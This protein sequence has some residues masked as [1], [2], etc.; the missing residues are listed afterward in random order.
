MPTVNFTYP[1]VYIE[2]ISSGSHA[3]TGVPTSVT[4][5]VGRTLMGPLNEPTDCF[6]YADYE[7]YFGGLSA[8]YPLAY[9][10]QDF[11]DNGGDHAI[12]VRVFHDMA[13]GLVVQ[14]ATATFAALSGGG[15]EIQAIGPGKFG[16]SIAL[17][18]DYLGLRTIAA[19]P[20]TATFE[21]TQ[22][23]D[24]TPSGTVVLTMTASPGGAVKATY[25]INAGDTVD[26]IAQG[27]ATSFNAA[28]STA[29]GQAQVLMATPTRAQVRFQTQT[30]GTGAPAVAWT[31]TPGTGFQIAATPPGTSATAGTF[32]AGASQSGAAASGTMTV[33]GPASAA[34]T[35]TF[36]ATSPTGSTALATVPVTAGQTVKSL[37]AGIQSAFNLAFGGPSG[38]IAPV[39]VD[40]TTF[41]LTIAA[42]QPG[43]PGNSVQIKQIGTLPAGVKVTPPALPLTGGVN[44]GY[45]DAPAIAAAQQFE[46]Y[47][48]APDDLF[49]VTVTYAPPGGGAPVTERYNSVSLT[50]E[51]SPTR[52]DRAI[53]QASVLVHV[54][55]SPAYPWSPYPSTV[56][57][58]FP[59]QSPTLLSAKGGS[60]S[61]ALQP[62]DFAGDQLAQTGMYA[63][64]TVDIFNLL[65][66]PPDAAPSDTLPMTGVGQDPGLYAAAADFCV[67]QRAMLLC[68]PPQAW[69]SYAQAGRYNLMQPTDVGITDQAGQQ[70]SAVY[71]P[72]IQKEDLLSGTTKSFS[73]VGSIAGQYATTDK[74][75]G[76]WKAPAGISTGLS[77]VTA[78]DFKMT[79]AQDGEINP[80]GINAL[81][82]FNVIGP[83]IWGARTLRGADVLA[84]DFKYV[85][86][87]RLTLY[88]ESSLYQG[89]Q[90]AVFEPNAEPLWSSLRLAVNG[91]MAPLQQQGA[92]YGYSVQCDSKTTTAADIELGVCNIIVAF[93]PVLPAEF[94]VLKIQQQT[95]ASYSS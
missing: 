52:I 79:D 61:P 19:T 5:F 73:P 51:H 2:E 86:A 90:W 40:P 43:V 33:G 71:F 63:L 87:R 81:R 36:L 76:V 22:A 50:G 24:A 44:P 59:G 15:A 21:L 14:N 72:R 65:C 17:S 68:D 70:N 56:V 31:L 78:L 20:A 30:A 37:A 10:V 39:T 8:S 11:F 75:R 26:V 27:L 1:G 80:L 53:N 92:F 91:F 64:Q 66:L 29:F 9:A 3:I 58:Q 85:S 93:A 49:N 12:V 48:V 41:A 32:A 34:G 23:R 60:D 94:I 54:P 77:G 95:A 35:L 74:A 38:F 45:S 55:A 88:I 28:G 57:F 7:R 62:A 69:A 25:A 4:A 6:G 47:G 82:W 42:A 46:Q 67:S 16:N 84:D 89:T 13:D 18:F 83:V